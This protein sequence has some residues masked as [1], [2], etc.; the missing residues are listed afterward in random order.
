MFSITRNYAQSAVCDTVFIQYPGNG[1][2]GDF[3]AVYYLSYI[4]GAGVLFYLFS[5]MAKSK[6]EKV[7]LHLGMLSMAV[8]T[9]PTFVFLIFLPRF[10]EQFPSVLCEFALLFAIQMIIILWYKDKRNLRY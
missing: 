5:N 8:F 7:L 2:I 3:Y 1:L 4:V 6:P 10:Y 9:F